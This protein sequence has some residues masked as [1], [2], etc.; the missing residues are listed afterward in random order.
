VNGAASVASGN[1]T[2]PFDGTDAIIEVDIVRVEGE[3]Q[4]GVRCRQ[5]QRGGRDNYYEFAIRDDGYVG[6]FKSHE[7]IAVIV[8]LVSWRPASVLSTQEPNRLVVQCRKLPD[9][10]FDQVQLSMWINGEL[11]AST[12]DYSIPLL[13]GTIALFAQANGGQTHVA[14]FDNLTIKRPRED[15]Q[16]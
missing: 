6:I 1:A 14:T 2:T 3:G 12:S 10:A 15:A 5:F 16:K 4:Y 8:P 9:A 7:S 13:R 11:V